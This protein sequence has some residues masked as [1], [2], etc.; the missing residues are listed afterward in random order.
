MTFT[1]VVHLWAAEQAPAVDAAVSD[2]AAQDVVRLVQALQFQEPAP[3]LCIVTRCACRIGD[4]PLAVVP[5][6]GLWGLGRTLAAEYPA[7]ACRLIDIGESDAAGGHPGASAAL[8]AE[9]MCDHGESEVVLRGTTRWVPRLQRAALRRPAGKAPYQLAICN[10]GSIDNLTFVAASQPEP[11][12]DELVIAVVAA[13]LNFKDV[14]KTLG[15]IDRESLQR[16]KAGETLGGEC[17]GRVLAVGANVSA[18]KVGDEV[19]AMASPCFGPIAVASARYV[20]QKPARMTFEEAATLPIAYL[21]AYFVLCETAH[22]RRGERLLIHS[23]AGGVGQA[24]LA[25]ARALGVEVLATAGSEEKRALLRRQ[26]I[27]HVMDSRST[28]FAEQTLQA[29]GGAGVD[30]ILNTLP[31]STIA[32]SLETLRP[33]GHLVDISNIYSGAAIDLRAFQKGVS[34]TAFDLDQLMRTDPDDIATVFHAAMRFV[35]EHDLPPLPH[36]AFPLR[37]APDAFR[38]MA[39]AQHVGKIVLLPEETPD[40]CV[41]VSL[42][43]GPRLRADATYLVVGGTSGLGLFTAGWLTERGARHV[44]L[45]SRSGRVADADRSALTAMRERGAKVRS[46]AGD[47]ASTDEL[48]RVLR[49]ID[50]TMAPLGGV[51][52]SAAIYAD[53]TVDKLNADLFARAWRPKVLGAWNLHRLTVD[54]PLDFFVVYSSVSV[55]F[56]SPGQAAYAAANACLEGLVE[57]RRALGLPGLAVAWGPIA[58]VGELMRRDWLTRYFLDHGLPPL[59]PATAMLALG[60]LLAL[61]APPTAVMAVQWDKRLR[62]APA[63]RFSRF[64]LEKADTAA[65]ESFA[66]RLAA[67]PDAESRAAILGDELA[68]TAAVVLGAPPESLDRTLPLTSIGLDSLMAIELSHRL[69]QEFAIEI[70]SVRLLGGPTVASLAQ[71]LAAQLA[72]PRGSE[73][74]T[75]APGQPPRAADATFELSYQQLP[76]WRLVQRAPADAFFNLPAA[77]RLR[78]PLEL[79]AFV[80]AVEQL[81]ERHAM[82]RARIEPRGGVPQQRTPPTAFSLAVE[83]VAVPEGERERFVAERVRA[84]ALQ[85]FYPATDPMFRAALV[86]FDSTDHALLIVAHHLAADGASLP[87]LLRDGLALYAAAVAG[88]ADTVPRPASSYADFVSWQRQQLDAERTRTLVAHWRRAL[89]GR[90][91]ALPLPL[92]YPRPAVPSLRGGQAAFLVA[93][94][95][96]DGLKAIARSEQSTL[97]MLLLTALGTLVHRLAFADD[98]CL[99]T[100]VANRQRPELSDIVGCFINQLALRIDLRG[101]PSLRQA[102]RR[103]QK[104]TL[105]AQAHAE[106]PFTL[107][108]SE[109]DLGLVAP[110]PAIQVVLILHNELGSLARY[111]LSLAGGLQV[112]FLESYN[113]GAKRDWTFHVYE[114]GAAIAGQLEYDADLFTPA[115]ARATADAFVEILELLATEP[116]KP[117]GSI[118]EESRAPARGHKNN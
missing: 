96:V 1:N 59:Q 99:G 102:L 65:H 49:E 13:G 104:T 4:E 45:L 16:T 12:P 115:T 116:D 92:D 26:G 63:A 9:L 111:R 93:P 75:A 64:L 86:R 30:V 36:Q 38:L 24:A 70:T 51:I 79:P 78:G 44:A 58:T 61:D 10:P 118:R 2:A 95:I 34:V 7:M 40:L 35:A 73:A 43:P 72:A 84:F 14:V 114:D 22:V 112:E 106:L 74:K 6:F 71:Q 109:L 76:I 27:E 42:S 97:F 28:A 31:S 90:I 100:F 77:I 53:F 89:D 113:G 5:P 50:D 60:V 17:A 56:G 83:E 98:F 67:A 66:N 81:V 82:L 101:K 18:F 108:T 20:A 3:G 48:G 23:A 33:R 88:H 107:L 94:P 117:V 62:T 37:R 103:V 55:V 85:P 29:T 32:R 15:L 11:G 39:Q 46:F 105:D 69:L 47:V 68:R 91:P 21:T 52:H 41:D 87:V 110:Q 80:F 8:F 19:I 54:R 57:Y 25:V